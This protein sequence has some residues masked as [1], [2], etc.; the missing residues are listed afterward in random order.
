MFR[1][2]AVGESSVTLS[3][4]A[5]PAPLARSANALLQRCTV[6]IVVHNFNRAAVLGCGTLVRH[7]AGDRARTCIV[8]AAH[9]FDAPG[10]STGNLLVAS[11]SQQAHAAL[12]RLSGAR[13]LRDLEDDVAVIDL[14]HAQHARA[15][16]QDR[17]PVQLAQCLQE[18]RDNPR[19]AHVL[20]GYPGEWSRFERGWLAARRLTVNT[21]PRRDMPAGLYE[22][23]TQVQDA[24]GCWIYTP[25]LEGMSGAGL[26]R[27]EPS[28][29][30]ARVL[31][32]GVQSSFVHSRYLRAAPTRALRR[33]LSA[34]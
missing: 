10:I 31:L 4:A 25:A 12:L 20:C 2:E 9:I 3:G 24:H 13:V 22:F 16:E 32:A 18:A 5:L 23:G 21:R 11:A 33:L 26:W 15:I 17:T 6:P 1:W 28:G 30:H 29:R 7:P 27:I 19:A 14:S 8:T 34:L